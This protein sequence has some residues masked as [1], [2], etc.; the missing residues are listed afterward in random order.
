MNG[1]KQARKK[2]S[3]TLQLRG[4]RWLAIWIVNGK[5]YTR[6]T[7]T[8]DRKEAEKKLAE[9]V[10]PFQEKT[11]LEIAENLA[12]KVRVR[13]AAVQKSKNKKARPVKILEM[14][15]VY[16]EDL[17]T[18]PIEEQTAG[19]YEAKVRAL[20]KKTGLTFAYEVGRAEAEKFMEGVKS[21]MS[22]GTFNIYLVA[23]KAMYKA[24]MKK[25]YRIRENPF[26]GISKLREDRSRGRRELSNEEVAKLISCA[27]EMSGDMEDL[28]VM[29]AYTGMRKSD[30]CN[31]KRASVDERNG[32]LKFRPVK[33]R[34]N[35]LH[36][37]VK[38]HEKAKAVLDSAAKDGE[39]V[40]PRLKAMYDGRT[41]ESRINAVF[42]AAGIET[43]AKDAAGKTTV[44]TG[45]HALRVYFAT[46]CARSGMPINQI[47]KALGHAKADMSLHYVETPDADLSLPDFG[48]DTVKVPLRKD[49]AEILRKRAAGRDLS[50]FVVE[51]LAGRGGPAS[52][53]DELRRLERE[54]VERM[55]DSI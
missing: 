6:S 33:T 11:E 52:D 42:R 15:D 45:F 7:G 21:K 19:Q 14:V 18:S 48:S 30:I 24:A 10:K 39:Y 12:A 49:V 20:A 46:N 54:A 43:H 16:R 55:V 2:G 13:T 26:A 22:A 50:D 37:V 36:A 40:F 38:I 47:M 51:L 28:F 9:F 35:G 29:G 31:L 3:G 4:G 44:V 32:L 41:L 1:R 5:R 34:K 27:A 25:D 17:S 23:L 53:D 8:G